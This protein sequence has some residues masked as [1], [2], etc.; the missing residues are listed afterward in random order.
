MMSYIIRDNQVM[1]DQCKIEW[2]ISGR[3]ARG[4]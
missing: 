3:W 2:N 1:N 4:Q